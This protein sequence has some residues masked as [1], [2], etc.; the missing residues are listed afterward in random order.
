MQEA[1]NTKVV[2]DAYAAFS[3]GDIPALLN[4]VADDVV[5]HGVYGGSA[6]VPQAGVRRG[7]AAVAEFFKLVG[8]TV[9]FSRFEPHDF[10]ATGDKVVTLGHYSG[11]VKTTGRTFDS[12]FAMVSTFRDGKIARF[13]EF[14]DSAAVNAAYAREAARV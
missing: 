5:W 2:Q 13:Q 10:I 4:L 12:D 11:T 7:R 3:K 9:A 1:Q 14:T 6:D 8:E